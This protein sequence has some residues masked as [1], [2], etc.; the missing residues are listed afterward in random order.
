MRRGMSGDQ[1]WDGDT[2]CLFALAIT[3]SRVRL[4]PTKQRA[5]A[6]LDL[7][8]VAT[9]EQEVTCATWYTKLLPPMQPANRL[10]SRFVG[11]ETAHTIGPRWSSCKLGFCPISSRSR[12]TRRLYGSKTLALSG[13]VQAVHKRIRSFRRLVD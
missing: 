9:Q 1:K 11:S 6:M 8:R 12:D 2:L 3:L 5:I 7:E 13:P 10:N 4:F